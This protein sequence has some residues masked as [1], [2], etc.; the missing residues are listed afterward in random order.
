[1]RFHLGSKTLIKTCLENSLTRIPQ[2]AYGGQTTNKIKQ[3]NKHIEIKNKRNENETRQVWLLPEGP[4]LPL[5][6]NKSAHCV[7][8][9]SR[10][11]LCL[12]GFLEG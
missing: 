3:K 10:W 7:H 2:A 12:S 1:M 11:K 5:M 8:C 6:R 4:Q 9:F